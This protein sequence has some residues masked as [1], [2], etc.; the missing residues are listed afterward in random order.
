M[1]TATMAT[2][3]G[4]AALLY[5]TLNRRL[6]VEKLNQEGDYGNGRD[7]A[8]RGTLSTTSRSRVSRRDVRAPATWLETISTLSETLRFTY[9]ETLGKW[10]IG[11][12]AFG[13]SFLLK[14]QGNVPVASIYAG[15]D[16]VELKGAPVIADLKHLLNLLTLC[17][18]FSKKPFSL[19][20]EATG[21]SLED[22]LMQEPK[23]GILKP[24]F[25]IILDRDKQCILLLI[26]GT[27]SIRDTLTAATG[28]VVPF[29][30]TIVQ[31]GGVSDLVLGYAHFGMVAAARWIA[32][33]AAPCLAQAL[34]A[35][36]DY[37]IKIVG[38]SL[39]G[40]TAALLT[41]VLRE[42]QEFASTTCVAFA[43]AACM[44]WDLAES[45]VH[46]ITTVINGADL[47]PT[48]SA[49]SVD[50]LRSE[51]TA[52]AWL[53]DLRHQIEQTRILSTFYRSAS[54]LGSRLPS[55]ANAKARVAGAG[56]I[57]RPVSTGTQVVMR[58]ARSVAQAAWTRPALQLSS[59][60][61]IGPRRRTNTVSTSTVT[62]E[63]I[64]TST[65]GDSESTSLLT[66]NTVETTQIV[67]TETMQFAASEEV[68]TS[69][70]VLDAVGMMDD[71]VDSDGE[72][73]IDH[74]VDEDRMTDVELWQQLEN[75]LYRRREDDEIV[76]EDMTESA[77]T[78]EVGGTAE[79]VLSETND[80]EVHRFY[81][82][83]K[84]MH[85]LTSSREETVNSD[86]SSMH[87]DDDVVSGDSDTRIGIFLTPRSLYGK[88]RLSKMMI[89]DHY[90]PIYRRNIEELIAE[91]EKDSSIPVSG[92]L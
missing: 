38:H 81:P 12:L 90:M 5:Y 72:D 43:P 36:P 40:G 89:N 64:R 84:I 33:L 79:D 73:I 8:T 80:K 34:H 92:S 76:E 37:K 6:Q 15:H 56:A 35:H 60:T 24:A 82:P 58:R 46:F 30:H 91:L 27:H 17:W 44:T 69:T 87:Q 49:A 31:E 18:H 86:E 50:D 21:Y 66:E 4:A 78:E 53:N 32:K 70:E 25:T 74:H 42:Q 52:S 62:S 1:A 13:I 11:D 54:A 10:P 23:A 67:E 48:F 47:V 19:F 3:A 14:R 28:A 55:I 7:A 26:R 61:C 39:G 57:L 75:E 85:I 63:E 41:Y 59:W 83:G 77:I 20:L 45:G 65:D 29:H 22:V 88:L 51:V 9:S 2:A 68:Q 71:K 16:C